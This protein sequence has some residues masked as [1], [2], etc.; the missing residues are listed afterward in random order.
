M[1]KTGKESE[2]KSLKA[3]AQYGKKHYDRKRHFFL[4]KI[5]GYK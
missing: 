1:N 2:R 4:H 3:I 5:A